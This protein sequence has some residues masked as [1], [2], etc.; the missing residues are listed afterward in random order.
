M[1][2]KPMYDKQLNIRIDGNRLKWLDDYLAKVKLE[3][4]Q[5]VRDR[6]DELIK[7]ITPKS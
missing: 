6:V 3:K 4:S 1:K 2:E 5:W 7:E